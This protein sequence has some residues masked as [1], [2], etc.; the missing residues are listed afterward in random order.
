[1]TV[2]TWVRPQDDR[3]WERNEE[4]YGKEQSR[5]V[6]LSE[7]PENGIYLGQPLD[8]IS[9]ARPIHDL[10]GPTGFGHLVETDPDAIAVKRTHVVMTRT[11]MAISICI[12]TGK[13]WPPF[14][15]AA[16]FL[17]GTRG[18]AWPWATS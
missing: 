13:R 14:L 4:Q 8:D 15:W 7:D 18:I 2:E 3:Q 5:I 6:T 12:L 11:P 17:I 1:M 9:R 16:T 10:V